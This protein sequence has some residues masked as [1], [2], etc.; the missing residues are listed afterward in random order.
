MN[1]SIII[2]EIARTLEKQNLFIEKINFKKTKEN[3]T[4]IIIISKKGNN[5]NG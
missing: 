4:A 1:K 3:K 2:S 5:K